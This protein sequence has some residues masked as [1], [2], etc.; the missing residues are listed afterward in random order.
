MNV[1]LTILGSAQDAGVPQPNC[2]C[3]NC[4]LAMIDS[5]YERTAASLAI[6]LPK[7]KE[8]H[9]ID[10]SPDFKVQMR[11]LQLHHQLQ[12]V[13]MKGIFLTH[14]HI[15]HY[16]GMMFLGKEAMNMHQL[17]VFAG[18]KMINM[19]TE[20]TP[21]Q[22]LVTDDNIALERLAH[23]E[24]YQI[25]GD[26]SIRPIDV[27]HR[28]EFSETFGFWIEGPTKKVLYIPDIDHWRLTNITGLA[29]E[30]DICLL[31][32]TFFSAQD[33]AHIKRDVSQIPHPFIVETM[34]RLEELVANGKTAVYF[35]HFNHSNPAIDVVSPERA[36]LEQ[37]G[38]NIAED[39]MEIVL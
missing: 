11:N 22:Q 24:S 1:I 35:T 26:V 16:P 34:D 10:C 2:F 27:P 18:D 5:T 31:D 37:R 3:E 9:L 12:G 29:S 39:G 8:W 38:F 4:Q 13:A 17:P 19:L 32:G 30:A 14:A 7:Q 20:N 25:N 33:L 6:I 21:W 36:M 23:G 15:G 28:N